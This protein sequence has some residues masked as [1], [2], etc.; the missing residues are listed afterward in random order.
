MHLRLTAYSL[1]THKIQMLEIR[2]ID[3]ANLCLDSRKE[4]TYKAA[5]RKNLGRE[6]NFW[7]KNIKILSFFF[8]T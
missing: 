2:A 3:K 4:K 5:K 8:I 1:A 6:K 7:I